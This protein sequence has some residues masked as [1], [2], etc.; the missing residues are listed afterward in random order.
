MN[1]KNIISAFNNEVKSFN[2]AIRF[3]YD[4]AK[5]ASAK[6]PASP[7]KN[8]Q[9]S[10]AKELRNAIKAAERTNELIADCKAICNRFHI[11]DV[12]AKSIPTY[13]ENILKNAP[14][15]DVNGNGVKLVKLPSYL[16][17]EI[18]DYTNVFAVAN[19][20]WIELI[21]AATE[22]A[23]GKQVAGLN[24]TISP[25]IENGE[26]SEGA[27]GDIVNCK[28]ET[29]ESAAIFEKWN[30]LASYK[31]IANAAGREVSNAKYSELTKE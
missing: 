18:A 27:N 19:T 24:V 12:K 15:L 20:T 22:N 14:M 8:D 29:L 6:V 16:K 17:N 31:N 23:E 26:V 4:T 3:I 2:S 11:V 7:E 25:T 10:E 1:A 9:S 5:L 21:I 13:R 28:G 30:K